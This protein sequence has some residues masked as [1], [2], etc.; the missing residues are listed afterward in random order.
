MTGGVG[1]RRMG[2]GKCRRH[3][4]REELVALGRLSGNTAVRR[5]GRQRHPPL[6]PP[7][8]GAATASFPPCIHDVFQV[9]FVDGSVPHPLL[10]P[11]LPPALHR[12]RSP[13]FLHFA[14]RRSHPPPPP[15]LR[16]TAHATLAL[17]A[18]VKAH[19]LSK[20]LCSAT[21]ASSPP[22]GCTTG[23]RGRTAV[24]G[25]TAGGMVG[26]GATGPQRPSSLA[27]QGTPVTAHRAPARARP[28]S[29]APPPLLRT[30]ATA[31]LPGRRRRAAARRVV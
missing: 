1:E 6:W 18:A 5:R 10:P 25:G 28:C 23:H 11:F 9:S 21:A 27:R 16:S 31:P 13:L 2:G 29:Q 8:F 24:A 15:A 26:A 17:R 7:P 3:P 20:R 22:S 19:P 4:G 30:T 12:P 14:L